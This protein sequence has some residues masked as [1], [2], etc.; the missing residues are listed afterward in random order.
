MIAPSDEPIHITFEL[1]REQL[2]DGS[3]AAARPLLHRSRK[4]RFA[5]FGGMG[6]VPLVLLSLAGK[7]VPGLLIFAG[8]LAAAAFFHAMAVRATRSAIAQIFRSEG[9]AGFVG[10]HEIRLDARGIRETT[11]VNDRLDAWSGIGGIEVD[12]RYVFLRLQGGLVH[13]V[14]RSA[15][16]DA[17]EADA[18][19]AAARRW[20]AAAGTGAD[21][22]T[23]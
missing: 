2:L 14:P 19:V 15:F 10:R 9:E 4:I 12:D 6:L 21:P 18:F 11:A 8:N 20:H 23:R 1:G 7:P 5:V 3:L 22:E 16:P 17:A 13:V